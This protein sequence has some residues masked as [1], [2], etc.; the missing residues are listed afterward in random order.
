METDR[1]KQFCVTVECGS[2]TKAGELLGISHSGLSKS[3]KILEAD[4]GVNLFI[5]QGRGLAVTDQGREVYVKAKDILLKLTTLQ[6]DST[7]QELP[8][9]IG[10][11]EVFTHH[12]LPK[13]LKEEFSDQPAFLFR[14]EKGSLELGL[15]QNKIDIGITYFPVPQDG[16]E[17]LKIKSTR[18]RIY[19]RG[20]TITFDKEMPF[21]LPLSSGSPGITEDRDRDGWPDSKLPRKG[22]IRTNE[23]STGLNLVL[24]HDYAIF[25]PEFVANFYNSHLNQKSQLYPVDVPTRYLNIKRDIYI[26]KRIST[27]EDQTMKKIAKAIR[28]YC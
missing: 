8:V 21:V 6:P 16:I 3:L 2:L 11:L 20:R 9:R 4:L 5:P 15:L 7:V 10:G 28:K 22:M 13:V 1:L 23:L 27:P 18:L 12:F 25:I 14:M 24:Y 19:K 17:Y 26:A